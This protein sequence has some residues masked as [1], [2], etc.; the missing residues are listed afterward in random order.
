M[1]ELRI[2]IYLS[3]KTQNDIGLELNEAYRDV[4]TLTN[5]LISRIRY[6]GCIIITDTI[7]DTLHQESQEVNEIN[8]AITAIYIIEYGRYVPISYNIISGGLYYNS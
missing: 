2:G 5:Q 7:S 4:P 1:F 6:N 3:V 8:G